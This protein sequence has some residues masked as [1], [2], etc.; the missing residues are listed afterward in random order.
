MNVDEVSDNLCENEDDRNVIDSSMEI[1][2]QQ[3]PSVYLKLRNVT[4]L[5]SSTEEDAFSQSDIDNFFNSD[6]E[7]ENYIPYE[8]DPGENDDL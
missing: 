1:D 8:F 4:R 5:F 3:Q 2:S 7:A 6:Y